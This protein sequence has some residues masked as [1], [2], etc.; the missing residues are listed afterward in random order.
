MDNMSL[1][2]L[3]EADQEMVLASLNSDRSPEA[4]EAA[5]EK[6]LDRIALRFGEEC[7]DENAR[8]A[9]GLVLKT[10]RSALP[11]M[12]SVNEVKRW[13]RTPGDAAKRPRMKPMTI[14]LLTVGVVLELSVMLGLLFTGHR[15]TGVLTLLEAIIPAGLGMAALFF[16]GMQYARPQLAVGDSPVEREEFL[17]SPD[18]VWHE[19][20]GMAL[21]ADS[22]VQ[23]EQSMA[24]Q[25]RSD[26]EPAAVGTSKVD[27]RQLELFSSLL[28]N[29]YARNDAD[30]REMVESI[31]FYLHGA[32][33]DALDY[34]KGREAWF[35]FL[36]AQRAGTIRP[37]LVSEGKV[38]KK[39][40]AA[41]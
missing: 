21:L 41:A 37:A 19:L 11:L 7:D 22:A 28:E 3:L 29:V 14:A 15:A 1:T 33:V 5:L 25:R 36:P 23:A 32:G 27:A 38:V 4:A 30:S 2:A 26:Q 8:A 16:A 24:S 6:S 18:R 12:A 39:G 20:K 13:Q 31:R 35:E 9:A 10:L 34:E 17:I 40:L